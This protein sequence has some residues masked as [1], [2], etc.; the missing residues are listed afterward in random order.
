MK[1]VFM[2]KQIPQLICRTGAWQRKDG[3]RQW[4]VRFSWRPPVMPGPV[5]TFQADN[6]VKRRRERKKRRDATWMDVTWDRGVCVICLYMFLVL[7]GTHTTNIACR[8]V[9]TALLITRVKISNIG[10]K[11]QE[12]KRLFLTD[13][14]RTVLMR[15]VHA[16]IHTYMHKNP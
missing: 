14:C 16:Y 7:I 8:N 2:Q 13:G 10:H 11:C 9:H 4:L 12:R 15:A 5:P 1:L 3:W 6:A